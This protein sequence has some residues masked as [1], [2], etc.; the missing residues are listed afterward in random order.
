MRPPI[1]VVLV[2]DSGSGKSTFASTFPGPMLVLWF[3][4][5][6]KEI[7]YLRRAAT[8][9]AIQEG[10][11]HLLM[12]ET[13]ING[14]SPEHM[15][16]IEHYNRLDP[17]TYNDFEA[18]RMRM[19]NSDF[20]AEGWRTV[21]VDS[22]TFLELAARKWQQLVGPNKDTREPRQWYAAATDELEA[23]LV[24]R[25]GHL[26]VNVVV[27]CHYDTRQDNVNG[28][29]VHQPKL[30]GRLSST[31]PAGY[32]EFYRAYVMQQ[33]PGQPGAH[34]L[35]TRAGAGYN[36]SSQIQAPDPCYPH[37]DSLWDAWNAGGAVG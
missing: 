36:A 34:V 31:V 14:H 35:Q 22:A 28:Q 23:F 11:S 2:G 15:I 8:P 30:P 10:Q 24:M 6:G 21:V 25:L 17:R 26:R 19:V 33:G 13:W 27:V 32:S 1:H 20:S 3:D 29:F 18:F 37:Y 7:P 4:Q 9:D 12:P 16:K 5:L